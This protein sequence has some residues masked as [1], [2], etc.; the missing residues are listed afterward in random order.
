MG[1]T[2]R[3]IMS[4]NS[5]IRNKTKLIIHS[6]LNQ[7]FISPGVLPTGGKHHF[8]QANCLFT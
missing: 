5:Y 8:Q 7:A 1:Y 3:L 2:A 4:M 6:N